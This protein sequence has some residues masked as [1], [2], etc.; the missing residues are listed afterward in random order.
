MKKSNF[1]YSALALGMMGSLA[2]CSNEDLGLTGGGSVGAG[3][4]V[5]RIAVDNANSL[6]TRA[7]GRPLTSEEPDQDIDHVAVVITNSTGTVQYATVVDN[8][9]GGSPA[10][11]VVSEE[12]GT[13][14]ATG[15]FYALNIPKKADGKYRLAAGNGYKVY[16][17]G[18]SDGTCYQVPGN[19]SATAL[20]TYFE[21]LEK[22][23]TGTFNGDNFIIQNGS[24]SNTV[25]ELFAGSATFNV[26]NDPETGVSFTKEVLLHRQVAGLYTYLTDIPYV[27][28]GNGN[29]A[30]YLR[31][32]TPIN[33]QKMVLGKFATSELATNGG[34]P[35]QN[36]VNG[37]GG[38]AAK[39]VLFTINLKSWF[40]NLKDE[41][42][43]LIVDAYATGKAENTYDNWQKP[44]AYGSSVTFQKGSVFG[45]EFLIPFAAQ[46]TSN[47]LQIE[48]VAAGGAEANAKKPTTAALRTWTIKMEEKTGN[49]AAIITWD[50]TAAE[51][52]GDWKTGTSKETSASAYSV[53]R[54]HL[55]G[56]GVRE[57]SDPGNGTD[58]DPDSPDPDDP[59]YPQ[60]LKNT[61]DLILRVNDNW[62]V[63]HHMVIE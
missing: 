21:N 30:D 4:Q 14:G 36:I 49:N 55:Y 54:N 15:R 18:F 48:L 35:S 17:I 23:Q 3:E 40:K 59:D 12:Y 32:V 31:V 2:S 22:A 10:G 28:D 19:P 39:S 1:L 63:I 46:G 33:N 43:D 53:L 44:T 51:G 61:Q 62:E 38:T 45:G 9:M 24:T 27:K 26:T 42:N 20:L 16:A 25:D 6:Q 7:A 52:A 56:V 41:N 34:N 60:P 58:P 5:I 8:W 50:A 11:S 29:V 13:T 47:S 37:F 57:D